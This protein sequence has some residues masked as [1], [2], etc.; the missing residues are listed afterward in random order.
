MNAIRA[1]SQRE[2]M[3]PTL[4]GEQIRP[5]AAQL[6]AAEPG[7]TIAVCA[8][9]PGEGVSTVLVNLAAALENPGGRRVLIVDWNVASPRLHACYGLPRGP[10]A[11]DVFLNTARL[12]HVVYVAESGTLAVLPAGNKTSA[13]PARLLS[14]DGFASLLPSLR[15]MGFDVVLID[16]PSL[17]AWPEAVTI[18][19][20]C[21]KTLI[22]VRAGKTTKDDARNVRDRLHNAGAN[23]AG[24]VLNMH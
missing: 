1:L 7:A 24:V 14:A 10:G 20:R 18:A 11:S 22:V 13:D 2:K 9:S 16:L 23:I 3:L 5:L 17:L 6:A 8:G 15:D 4:S 12:R 19:A 21:T